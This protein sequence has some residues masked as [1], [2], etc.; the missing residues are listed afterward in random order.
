MSYLF[1]T[2]K[3]LIGEKKQKEVWGNKFLA[4]SI[5]RAI[6]FAI[7][8]SLSVFPWKTFS[9]S[10]LTQNS[11]FVVAHAGGALPSGKGKM[12]TYLNTVDGFEKYYDQGTRIFEF[13]FVFSKDG[14][15][16]GT[17]KFE[18]FDG[19]SLKNRIDFEEYK[20]TRI[21][22]LYEGITEESLIDIIKKHP[23]CKIIVDTKEQ[24]PIS[25]YERIVELA[26]ERNVELS[27]SILP[28]V[29]SKDML[30]KIQRLYDFDEIMLT[31]YKMFYSTK[32]L[33]NLIENN[34]KI[35]YLHV[36]PIDFFQTN[37]N[38]IN[39]KNVRI[40][41]HMDSNNKTKIA[42]RNGCSGIFSDDISESE[43][44]EKYNHIIE[45]KFKKEDQ[46]P[47]NSYDL[48]KNLS[49]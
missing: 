27:S 45:N 26:K 9:N 20:K 33:L 16:I 48:E 6:A 43:F 31:N 5:G 36:F 18:Y 10:A 25:V 11:F 8:R 24:N 40:F 29:S 46:A 1:S 30:E 12:L 22:G 32:K 14:K 28:F 49:L 19:Y 21:A 23:E 13:D 34:E 15:L 35:K 3:A 47:N 4:T 17:H 2:K 37:F 42:L 7:P 41:A 38:L 44:R 39:K